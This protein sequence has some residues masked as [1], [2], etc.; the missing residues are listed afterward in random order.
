MDTA[1]REVAGVEPV[2]LPFL[3]LGERVT[4][5]ILLSSHFALPNGL[6]VSGERK[7]VRCTRVL[8]SS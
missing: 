5:A 2:V 4:L 7:R 3:D 6:R 8:G 1:A